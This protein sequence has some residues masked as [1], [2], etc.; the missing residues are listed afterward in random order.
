MKKIPFSII[1]VQN[2][3]TY[4]DI[5]LC[6]CVYIILKYYSFVLFCFDIIVLLGHLTHLRS[7]S[8]YESF[9]WL[10]EQGK[11]MLCFKE[12]YRSENENTVMT[13]A[14]AVAS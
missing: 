4:F 8:A 6:P 7:H 9:A 11:R 13:N 10:C 2:I 5:V 1:I 3:L 12:K 14:A